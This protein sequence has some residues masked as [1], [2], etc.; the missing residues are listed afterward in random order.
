VS[1][2]GLKAIREAGLTVHTYVDHLGTELAVNEVSGDGIS[3]VVVQLPESLPL[4]KAQVASSLKLPANNAKQG[5]SGLAAIVPTL[6]DQLRPLVDPGSSL[7]DARKRM[8]DRLKAAQMAVTFVASASH[9]EPARGKK[10]SLHDT[11]VQVLYEQTLR[12]LE[13]S[14]G[15]IKQL[16][17]AMKQ[18]D[19]RKLQLQLDLNDGSERE[20]NLEKRCK[21]LEDELAPARYEKLQVQSK[22]S[23]A[24]LKYR[25]LK[26][27]I[28][29]VKTKR[30]L[31]LMG[32]QA[33]VN[34][35]TAEV[36]RW[37]GIQK[38]AAPMLG[39]IE[40]QQAQLVRDRA[41]LRADCGAEVAAKASQG[42]ASALGTLSG[43]LCTQLEQ[44]LQGIHSVAGI[45]AGDDA[46]TTTK[47]VSDTFSAENNASMD[48]EISINSHM[49]AS[50]DGPGSQDSLDLSALSL[51]ASDSG[52]S[53]FQRVL[54][55]SLVLKFQPLGANNADEVQ[56]DTPV[57]VDN[58]AGSSSS[59]IEDGVTALSV[60]VSTPAMPSESRLADVLES[61]RI[62]AENAVQSAVDSSRKMLSAHQHATETEI[63]LLDE[64]RTRAEGLATSA[65]CSLSDA[66]A[67]LEQAKRLAPPGSHQGMTVA[68][69]VLLANEQ[70]REELIAAKDKLTA[71][72]HVAHQSLLET[73]RNQQRSC[74]ELQG[75]QLANQLA[76]M[77]LGKE[78]TRTS[79]EL[80]LIRDS[81]GTRSTEYVALEHKLVSLT[82]RAVTRK[83]LASE[84]RTRADQLL[85]ATV[86]EAMLMQR[87]LQTLFSN[88]VM[89]RIRRLILQQEST[90]AAS[91]ASS[92]TGASIRTKT[93]ISTRATTGAAG[94]GSLVA[95]DILLDEISRSQPRAIRS[96]A[97][98]LASLTPSGNRLGTVTQGPGAGGFDDEAS[99][100]SLHSFT[101]SLNGSHGPGTEFAGGMP[102][103]YLPPSSPHNRG[104]LAPLSARSLES[105]DTSSVYGYGDYPSSPMHAHAHAHS[106]VW[107]ARLRSGG[108]SVGSSS[109][110][111]GS[112][113]SGSLVG[114]HSS[115]KRSMKRSTQ[116]RQPILYS[117][118]KYNREKHSR[119][120]GQQ[121][122]DY[123]SFSG[124]AVGSR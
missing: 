61:W 22:L 3:L 56:T 47:T 63:S 36:D 113:S 96:M 70:L 73:L 118:E 120:R 75:I 108:A 90:S 16:H 55:N 54:M 66:H 68:Q 32:H 122:P 72:R 114:S 1:V 11:R 5:R 26:E 58:G 62:S 18:S 92:E 78:T 124:G 44:L 15:E 64:A 19:E 89:A 13:Q 17:T 121:P 14:Y 27:E 82:Q 59:I 111:V 117:A 46:T 41:S 31:Q 77:A 99:I 112:A 35:L 100:G 2:A 87:E 106:G 93:G 60:R 21:G 12:Q 91:V 81:Q 67:Q 65:I 109:H 39:L 107:K 24:E 94:T 102:P 37:K 84:A 105:V 25:L 57:P 40:E 10:Q 52:K 43:S 50:P 28:V 48:D 95:A 71:L 49:P 53:D 116:P 30:T 8:R 115:S 83:R 45:S 86:E 119:F 97:P 79:S 104:G 101:D 7:E 6:L 74:Q 4:R 80:A 42:L 34:T 110:S 33:R 29:T 38:E 9:E 51:F 23:A 103:L 123:R 20:A 98:G 69:Q 88:K 76:A 85:R